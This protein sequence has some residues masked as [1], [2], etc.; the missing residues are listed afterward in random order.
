MEKKNIIT[1]EQLDNMPE[2]VIKTLFLQM[3]DTLQIVSSQLDSVTKQY[4]SI[5]EQLAILTQQKFG[6][7]TEVTA[8]FDERQLVYDLDTLLILNEAEY[9]L[10]TC[11]PDDPSMSQVVRTPR[12]KKKGKR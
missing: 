7:K 2:D 8:T 6:R 3:Q 4:E 12:V 9:I 1:Q 11:I 10:E 5:K